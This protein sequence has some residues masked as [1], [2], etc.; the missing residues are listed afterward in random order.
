[1]NLDKG[2]LLHPHAFGVGFRLLEFAPKADG[3]MLA[4]ALLLADGNGRGG[5]DFD[6]P[7]PDPEDIIGRWAGDRIIVTGDMADMGKFC[8]V[9][10]PSNLYKFSADYFIDISEQV[11]NRI[12]QQETITRQ[13]T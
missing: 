13:N 11:I 2:E 3:I 6:C 10:Y 1:M 7:D 12:A 4:L 8:P 5:G 9:D